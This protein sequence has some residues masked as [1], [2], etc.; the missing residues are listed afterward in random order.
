VQVGDTIEISRAGRTIVDPQTKTVLRTIVDRVGTAKVT[1]VDDASSTATLN[2]AA[3]VQ[4]GDQV[5]RVP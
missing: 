1:E 4:V 2:G 5:K 3:S